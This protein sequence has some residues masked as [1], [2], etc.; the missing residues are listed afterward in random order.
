MWLNKL[1][2]IILRSIKTEFN[3]LF[4]VRIRNELKNEIEEISNKGKM[5]NL[6]SQ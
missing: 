4:H 3:A 2:L 5:K 1:V 6:C